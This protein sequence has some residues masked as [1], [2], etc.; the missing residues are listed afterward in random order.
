MK[1]VLGYLSAATL[2]LG[3]CATDGQSPAS[4]SPTAS[5]RS[6]LASVSS[7]V[8]EASLSRYSAQK[9][10]YGTCQPQSHKVTAYMGYGDARPLGETCLPQ[11]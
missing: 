3:G 7:D 10:R 4:P 5:V 9:A 11:I 8:S 6:A 1:A 2:L